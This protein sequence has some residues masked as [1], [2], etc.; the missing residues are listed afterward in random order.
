MKGMEYFLGVLLI[1]DSVRNI[2]QFLFIITI[3][4]AIC[5]ASEKAPFKNKK[6]LQYPVFAEWDGL[7]AM[8]DFSERIMIGLLLFEPLG[9]T[10]LTF[11]RFLH[12][13]VGEKPTVQRQKLRFICSEHG[14]FLECTSGKMPGCPGHLA[15]AASSQVPLWRNWAEHCT[16]QDATCVQ[17][18]RHRSP[19]ED[20]MH[21]VE[22][23]MSS[24]EL[25]RHFPLPVFGTLP[26]R[27]S[28]MPTSGL[29][30][31]LCWHTQTS[32]LFFEK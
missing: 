17:Q 7:Q 14:S 27:Q 10:Q 8:W 25:S 30:L 12:V 26:R 4:I 23:P 2:M 29:L 19:L 9:S 15:R 5:S 3:L 1:G 18:N 20:K 32:C 6:W 31:L 13:Q 11:A 21:S 28:L 16:F 22:L 24:L